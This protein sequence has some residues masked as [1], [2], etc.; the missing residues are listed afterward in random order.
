LRRRPRPLE[1]GDRRASRA[2]G[3]DPGG[4]Q[5]PGR[6]RWPARP[7][8][9]RVPQRQAGRDRRPGDGARLLRRPGRGR[10]GGGGPDPGGG[11]GAPGRVG[12]RRSVLW[13]VAR[14]RSVP[15]GPE[16]G[17]QLLLTDSGDETIG[18]PQPPAPAELTR[19][20]RPAMRSSREGRKGGPMTVGKAEM[21]ERARLLEAM[22]AAGRLEESRVALAAHL[23]DPAAGLVALPGDHRLGPL[24]GSGPSDPQAA[25]AS[26]EAWIRHLARWGK[27]AWVRAALAAARGALADWERREPYALAPR[28]AFLAAHRW[29]LA[30][31]ELTARA[32]ERAAHA[33]GAVR[34]DFAAHAV[35]QVAW[36]A[37]RRGPHSLASAI[38]ASLSA[39]WVAGH[40]RLIRRAVRAEL[41]PWA[42]TPG[43]GPAGLL[44]IS[45]AA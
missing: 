23:G 43:R 42:L 37:A 7:R 18:P 44:A 33:C 3:S 16:T 9:A 34:D 45:P 8:H 13:F 20:T 32:A 22:V 19:G 39:A 36:C 29:L 1:A 21:I 28:R 30:P 27:E 6:R 38:Q 24:G 4:V 14:R 5:A 40:P 31:C 11:R 25:R 12:P 17:G 41:L 2:L 10:G 26:L 35:E 15:A